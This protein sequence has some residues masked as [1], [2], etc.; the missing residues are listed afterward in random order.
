MAVSRWE[1]AKLE[2]VAQVYIQLGNHAGEPQ[3]W[4]F[5][6]RAGLKTSSLKSKDPDH[7]S[8]KLKFA[9]FHISL[10]GVD[11]RAKIHGAKKPLKL[12][13]LPILPLRAATAD[14]TGDHELNFSEI[15]PESVIAAPASWCPHP[16]ATSCLHVKG[17]AMGPRINNGDIVAVDWSSTEPDVLNG[18]VILA[19]HRNRGLALSRFVQINGTQLLT[20]DNHSYAPIALEKNRDWQL[21]GKVLWCIN[22]AP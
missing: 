12:V 9:D 2:P 13:A 11:N 6:A 16:A 15:H 10:A 20:A 5:W 3:C 22:V 14:E 18:K 1:S 19:W 17:T 7:A 4:S 8:K 21:V